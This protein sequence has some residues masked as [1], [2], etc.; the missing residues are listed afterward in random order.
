MFEIM[1][2]AQHFAERGVI[3]FKIEPSRRTAGEHRTAAHPGIQEVA[4]IDE[5][6]GVDPGLADRRQASERQIGDLEHDE[7]HRRGDQPFE[8]ELL[9]RLSVGP[10]GARHNPDVRREQRH[11][12][13]CDGER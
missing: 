7:K 4:P 9:D 8:I 2:G 13:N 3:G 11:G 10:G 1:G 6:R 12:R 5:V